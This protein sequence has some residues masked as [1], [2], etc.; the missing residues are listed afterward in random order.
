[1]RQTLTNKN[2]TTRSS[3]RLAR[4]ALLAGAVL[5]TALAAP[6]MAAA[7]DT[8]VA[9]DPAADQITA[10]DDTVVW[11]SGKFGN[12]TLM[13][14]NASGVIARVKGAPAAKDY[15]SIDLGH[16]SKNRLVLTYQRC[17]SSA[18]KTLTDN[19]KGERASFK[20]L[21]LRRCTLTTAPARWGDRTAY[22]QLCRKTNK[23]IDENR[24]GLYVKNASGTIKRLRRPKDAKKFHINDITSVDIR[25]T[26]VAAI[27]GEVYEYAFA[28]RTNG[29]S[30]R[31]IFAAASEGDSD[32]SARGLALGSGGV[33]WALTTAAHAG[34][35]N[36]AIIFRVTDQCYSSASLINPPGPDAENGYLATDIAVDGSTVYLA[37]PGTGI[38]THEFIFTDVCN[39]V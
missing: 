1:M 17:S 30:F 3:R 35:P 31:F 10:L 21:T 6:G 11:V 15:R 26:T 36:R 23:Q 4:Q 12:Q 7:A 2:I 18:C 14:R 16:D 32:Q 33:M 19:L 28:Q 9:P 34:D 22:G 39:P 13:Q 24:S 29:K 25:G 20:H 5:A 8:L 38:V 37:V 27:I